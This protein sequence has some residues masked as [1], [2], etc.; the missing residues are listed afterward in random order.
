MHLA[1][2]LFFVGVLGFSSLGSATA[3]NLEQFF[4]GIGR[5]G[6]PRRAVTQAEWE[7]ISPAE[8]LCVDGRLRRNRRSINA[9]IDRGIGPTDNR[10]AGIVSE[11]QATTD[12]ATPNATAPNATA[13]TFN[14]NA[15]SQPDEI[16]ICSNPELARLD[17]A[18]V[19]GYE[20]VIGSDGAV[21]AKGIAEPLLRRRHG[22]GS[23][24]D[25]IKRVQLT[26]IAAFQ[27]RG[28]PVQV[29]A[30]AQVTARDNAAAYA[31]NGMRLGSSVNVGSPD[32]LDYACAPSQQY[33]GFTECQR[34][35][36]ERSRRRRISES[37]AF[38]HGADGAVVYINQSLDPVV[39]DDNDAHDEIGR[40]SETLGKATLLPM[41]DARGV[42]SGLIA[43]WGAVSLQP[44]ET[45]RRAALAAGTDDQPGILIDSINNLQSSAQLGLP[46]YRLGGGAGY[47][48]SASWNGRGR[49]TLR[50]VAIDPSRLPGA[51]ADAKPS[52]ETAVV[53]P[54]PEAPKP[55]DAPPA[56]AS[57]QPPVAVGASPKAADPAPVAQPP[58]A[59][60]LADVRV[61]G[62]PIALRPNTPAPT[63]APVNTGGSNGLVIFLIALVVVL[64]GAVGYL[65][66]KTRLAVP[67]AVASAPAV[68]APPVTATPT[69]TVVA[70]ETDK[71]DLPALVPGESPDSIVASAPEMEAPKDA[72]MTP[73][74]GDA[75][76]RDRADPPAA[77]TSENK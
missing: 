6:Q 42:P 24:I 11:C 74:A 15:A 47:V 4:Q 12:A 7:R 58:K 16:A 23:D 68:A 48:W 57:P 41:L 50:L 60:P 70:S 56:A 38:L 65:F 2:K 45:E 22:C 28:A 27:A 73:A 14:C 51:T 59:A 52:A 29:P 69:E 46:I 17:R 62:P 49:G 43:S 76:K 20:H 26:A 37:T 34:Q 10:V 71:M 53:T 64:L 33:A 1:A 39:M 21:V 5:L 25:C 72:A 63:T 67:A 44:L 66:R 18:V 55:A 36:A 3:Q 54:P 61:V 13:P 75:D 40:L 35:T 30:A 8:I 9:L 32:Y 31:I 19:E 77:A